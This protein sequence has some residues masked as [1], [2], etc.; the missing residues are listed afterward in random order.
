[1]RSCPVASTASGGTGHD[2]LIGGSSADVLNGGSGI[3]FLDGGRDGVQDSLTGGSNTD[4]FV[5][6][7]TFVLVSN[8]F[9]I[10]DFNPA[11]GDFLA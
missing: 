10:T 7:A 9:S 4:T 1:M 3:D 8:E 11:E 2:V 5:T 6:Y